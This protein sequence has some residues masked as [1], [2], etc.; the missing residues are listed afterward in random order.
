VPAAE[1]LD[2]VDDCPLTERHRLVRCL[3]SVGGVDA[4]LAVSRNQSEAPGLA[5]L[6]PGR[7]CKHRW[8]R[9][10]VVADG[11]ESY[12]LHLMDED[13]VSAVVPMLPERGGRGRRLSASG[14]P[15]ELLLA[16]S[17]LADD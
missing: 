1:D 4:D 2:G 14:A 9:P 11:L 5:H 10:E 6:R 12:G 3:D 15:L 7:D 16:A 13:Q 8:Q 17:R